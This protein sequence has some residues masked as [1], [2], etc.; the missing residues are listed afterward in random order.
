MWSRITLYFV[1][2]CV[3]VLVAGCQAT[4]STEY[5]PVFL[6]LSA[7]TPTATPTPTVPP[8]PAASPTPTPIPPPF[9]LAKTDNILLLGT[10]RRPDWT[11]WRTDSIMIIGLDHE[12]NRA[13]VLSIPRDLYV[14][15]PGYGQGRINQIDYLGETSLKT[16][17]GGPALLSQ[18]IEDELGIASNHWIRVEMSGFAQMVDALGGVTVHLDC[19]FYELIYDLDDQAWTYF[20]LPAGDVLMDGQTSYFFVTLRL[21]ESDIGRSRRQ[22]QFLWALRDQALDTNLIVRLPEL[23]TAFNQTFSTDFSLLE[24]VQL[25][26]FGLSI[27]SDNVRS[28][29]L[30][31]AELE[32]YIT[33]AGADVLRIGDRSR[34]QSVI[35]N[36]WSGASLAQ[37]GRSNPN[38][39]PPPP[40]GVPNYV[41]Q[42][43]GVPDPTV[44]DPE[45]DVETVEGEVSE[46]I[47]G[48]GG[49]SADMT[50]ETTDPGNTETGNTE[51]GNTETG[52]TETGNTE[53]G[54]TET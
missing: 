26:R 27:D 3:L 37:T 43:L 15:I 18:V 10:D 41:V 53:T 20:E 35:D 11:N 29:A 25:A 49:E 34:V 51:T 40:Q 33:P 39:C 38:A 24:M 21:I 44:T 1:T 45:A 8:T 42:E 50:I 32:R 48:S 9:N 52:N 47:G 2:I 19:P 4:G 13:A 14:D 17:G 28:A 12:Y 54:N 6:G 16:D 30:T 22:R 31:T 46:G 36:V 23:W 7:A 5:E